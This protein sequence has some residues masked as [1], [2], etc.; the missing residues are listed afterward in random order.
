MTAEVLGIAALSLRVALIA[1]LVACA[2]GIPFGIWLGTTVFAGRRALLVLLNAALALPTVVVGLALYLVLSRHGPL[3]V[4]GLLFTSN[5]IIIAEV[6]L[7]FPIAAS[8]SAAAVQSLDPR[9]LRTAQT[10][11]AGAFRSGWALAREA[12][13]ALAV[14]AAVAFGRVFSEIGAALIVGGNIRHE[15]RTLTTAV[16]LATSQGDFSLAISLALVLLA[17]AITVNA[18]V[19]AIQGRR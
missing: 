13:A 12:R 6:V 2:L 8:L 11:G 15:T 10:L 4:L 9:I 5:A 16:T 7:A 18:A 3:G 1:T 14:T 19:Q 17:I